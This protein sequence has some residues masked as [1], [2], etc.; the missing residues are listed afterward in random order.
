MRRIAQ[1]RQ[2][3]FRSQGSTLDAGL[4]DLR[5]ALR[6]LSGKPV[7]A[8]VL[9][10]TLALGLGAN[11]TAFSFLSGY[12]LKPLPYPRPAELA[13]GFTIDLA[14]SDPWIS[15][16]YS[17]A[18]KTHT[19]AFSETAFYDTATFSL[20]T[21]TRAERVSGLYASASLSKLLGARL[22][23]GRL[24]DANNM[25]PGDRGVALISYRLWQR[26]FGGNPSVLGKIITLDSRPYRVIGVFVRNFAF[27]DRTT[28]VWIPYPI[29][30]PQIT[31]DHQSVAF[32]GRLGPGVSFRTA[33]AQVRAAALSW[34]LH[35]PHAAFVRAAG[36]VV[37]VQ[38]W[39][40]LLIAGRRPT[41]LLLQSAAVIL[42]GLI[43]VNVANLLLSRLLVREQE[44][45]ARGALGAT[46]AALARQIFAEASCVAILGGAIGILLSLGALHFLSYALG[47]AGSVI[48][49]AID[50][51]VGLFTLCAILAAAG[52]VSVLPILHLRKME[53]RSVLQEANRTTTGSRGIRQVRIGLI[54][55][56][57]ALATGMLAVSGLIVHSYVNL[58]S[59]DPGFRTDH[60]LIASLLVPPGDHTG[61]AA[62]SSFYFSIVKRIDALPGVRQAS[63]AQVLPFLSDENIHLFAM[64]PDTVGSASWMPPEATLN[65]ITPG[66][67][68]AMGIPLIR[69]RELGAQDADQPTVIVDEGLVRKYFHRENPIGRQISFGYGP[70]TKRLYTIVGVV[71]SVRYADLSGPPSVTIYFDDAHWPSRYINVVIHTAVSPSVFIRAFRTLMGSVDPRV[72]VWKVA[73]LRELMADSL[74]MKKATLALLLV[75]G[76]IA[77][78]LAGIG[79]YA[80]L[81]YTVRQRYTEFGIRMALGASPDHVSR[82]VLRDALRLL[83]AG[84]TI[85]LVL[86]VVAGH[87]MAAQLFG[88][89]PLDP[90]AL[91]GSAALMCAIT[92]VACYIPA[93]SAARLDPARAIMAC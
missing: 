68:D 92:F 49:F 57:L 36:E 87:L 56:E 8:C 15:L 34:G 62:L 74:R 82:M 13:R 50:W 5:F 54:V 29:R 3:E 77:M 32:I 19:S 11:T 76:G 25:N 60:L 90:P 93:R 66:Y 16:P 22:L 40:Q 67:F 75:F 12:L 21:G 26:S 33:N 18:I 30:T 9:I 48:E 44:F 88:V 73:T 55:A 86:A 38:P 70:K 1:Q 47:N 64:Q 10:L 24:F 14:A 2:R 17:E 84:L 20:N 45:A 42:L 28:K 53:L 78:M 83:L 65:G 46:Y 72:A 4:R 89:T 35:S 69:G 91:V 61:N 7:F 80:V 71:P 37:G 51:R 43:C 23:F 6:Q 27:P 81:S 41:L 63:V 85:G 52:L 31:H 39:R 59:V 79:V 58:E